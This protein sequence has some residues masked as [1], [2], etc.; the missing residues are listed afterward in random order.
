MICSPRRLFG[1]LDAASV[2]FKR[3]G[4]VV[5]R[6]ERLGAMGQL[7]ENGGG[8]GAQIKFHS[9]SPS[10]RRLLD[11]VAVRFSDRALGRH[12]AH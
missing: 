2:A 3:V 5:E 10:T 8:R 6:G 7:H 1:H 4:Q 11:C 12:P 9:T